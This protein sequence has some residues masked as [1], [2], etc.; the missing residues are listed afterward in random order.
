MTRFSVSGAELD[1]DLTGK[2]GLPVVQ[3]HGL[4]SSKAQDRLDLAHDVRD[5]R[6]LR[7]DARGHGESTGRKIP[8][9]YRWEKLAEDLLALLDHYFP[10]EQVY[11]IGTS[12]GTG[13]LLH[14]ALVD[15]N[16]FCGL[17]LSA[18][19]TAWETRAAQGDFYRDTAALI[20][21][22]G[23]DAFIELAKD[24]P[25]PP[26]LADYPFTEPGVAEDVF[27]S[28]FRGAALTD[29]PDREDIAQIT[30]PAMILP[31][32]D[33]PGHPLSTAESL[34]SIMPNASMSVAH[35]PTERDTWRGMVRDH[36]A[37]VAA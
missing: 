36:V 33:D 16:R 27:P 20:E 21:A 7:Y 4:T 32:S 31:W 24:A 34:A 26:A 1:I 11:G 5:A 18:P 12:M 13:T 37:R 8:E 25:R 6:V 30:V 28:V 15:R 22:Q 9:D 2:T 35:N 3:L 23:V 10:G 29:L 14:A 19:P 17:T